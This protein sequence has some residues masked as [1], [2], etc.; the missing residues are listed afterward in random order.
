MSLNV[1][2]EIT[3]EAPADAVWKVVGDFFGL[4]NWLPTTTCE[5]PFSL[6]TVLVFPIRTKSLK[7]S[8]LIWW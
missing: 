1:T 3:I 7:S 2:E 6:L 8:W 5:V 4:S